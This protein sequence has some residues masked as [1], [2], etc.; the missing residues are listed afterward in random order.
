MI[1]RIAKSLCVTAHNGIY[2]TIYDLQFFY[3]PS[4]IDF[5]I[6]LILPFDFFMCG[7]FIH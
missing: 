7:N 5:S 4:E 1:N 3:S 2:V 6:Q